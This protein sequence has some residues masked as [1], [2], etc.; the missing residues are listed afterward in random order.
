MIFKQFLYEQFKIKVENEKIKIIIHEKIFIQP[1]KFPGNVESSCVQF[2]WFTIL[3]NRKIC[4]GEKMKIFIQKN[5]FLNL[6][7]SRVMSKVLLFKFFGILSW[8]IGKYVGVKE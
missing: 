8:K 7:N 2:F 6:E 3:E 4:W 5:V 1:R